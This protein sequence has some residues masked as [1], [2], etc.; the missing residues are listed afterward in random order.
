[1]YPA[2]IANNVCNTG[3]I[4]HPLDDETIFHFY[5][6]QTNCHIDNDIFTLYE[7]LKRIL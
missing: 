1:M 5:D 3:R 4:K 2:R 7:I 6:N